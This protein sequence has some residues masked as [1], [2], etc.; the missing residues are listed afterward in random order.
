[1][2]R[3]GIVGIGGLG[4]QALCSLLSEKVYTLSL[5]EHDKVE[6]HNLH[7]QTLYN[8]N[9]LGRKKIEVLQ[10]VIMNSYE[11]EACSLIKFFDVKIDTDNIEHSLFDCNIVIDATDTVQT[12]IMLHDESYRLN[13]IF[14]HGAALQYI[15]RVMTIIPQTSSCLR[16]LFLDLEESEQNQTCSRF[17]VSPPV[18][19]LAGYYQ[20]QEALSLMKKNTPKFLNKLLHFDLKKMKMRTIPI[21]KNSE[22]QLCSNK[23]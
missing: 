4:T 9:H 11:K 1:M 5:F 12:K 3:I 18:V 10:E 20:A 17:G 22:C 6:I 19:K 21:Q 15:G 16:C 14:I 7:R 8:E 2:E 13:K 23:T